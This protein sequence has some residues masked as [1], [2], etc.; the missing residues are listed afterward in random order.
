[1]SDV[2][3]VVAAGLTGAGIAQ[4]AAQV[5]YD[6]RLFDIGDT[7]LQQGLGTIERSVSRLVEKGQLDVTPG[8][9][10]SRIRPT[11]SLDDLAEAFIAVEA[12]FERL[13]VKQ[14]VF[15]SLDAVLGPDAVLATNT[16]ALPVT[17]LA[18]VTSRPDQ[19]VGTHFFSPVPMMALCELV[20]GQQTSDQTLAVAREFAEA[21]G[22]TCVVVNRDIAG[23]VTTRLISALV[24]E[25][26]KLVEDGIATPADIDVACRLG[27]GHAMG[28]LETMDLVGIDVMVDAADNIAAESP[29]TTFEV[30][31]L[32]RDMARDGRLG[33]KT[34]RG[35]YEY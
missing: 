16:S 1:M 25:A 35:F 13:D 3:A 20:R 2:V 22:K 7:A 6:V 10:L 34:G 28:P 17:Q 8:V 14:D 18:A 9:V 12:V 24:V 23:F 15:R 21:V 32:L 30:P 5:G 27:F 26:A 4:V 31:G 11:T 29:G 33:R 19:V